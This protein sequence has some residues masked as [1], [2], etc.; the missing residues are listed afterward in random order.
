MA[1]FKIEQDDSLNK[2][3]EDDKKYSL[4]GKCFDKIIL[5]IDDFSFFIFCYIIYNRFISKNLKSNYIYSIEFKKA[6]F[7]ISFLLTYK[8]QID[9]YDCS[10]S[11]FVDDY[12][13]DHDLK[14]ILLDFEQYF[15]NKIDWEFFIDNK[16]YTETIEEFNRL[17]IENIKNQ[18]I[19]IYTLLFSV[20]VV[21]SNSVD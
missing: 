14:Q 4:I 19:S 9:D 21:D 3:T 2:L 8:I 20:E 11:N 17:H 12:D 18:Y 1:N 16:D 10:I 13:I 7:V 5:N 15:S 6:I